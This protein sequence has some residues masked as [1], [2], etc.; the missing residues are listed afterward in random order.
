MFLSLSLSFLVP[1]LY[2]LLLVFQKILLLFRSNISYT[3]ILYYDLLYLTV[4]SSISTANGRNCLTSTCLKN[5]NKR[6][7]FLKFDYVYLL[8]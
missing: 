5:K 1:F 7:D 2:I 3:C 4:L 6:Q 8:Q